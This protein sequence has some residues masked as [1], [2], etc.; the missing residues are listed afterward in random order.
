MLSRIRPCACSSILASNREAVPVRSSKVP[1][2]VMSPRYRFFFLAHGFP[3][4]LALARGRVSHGVIGGKD[5]VIPQHPLGIVVKG[6]DLRGGIVH[7][8]LPRLRQPVLAVASLMVKRPCRLQPFELFR[9][10]ASRPGSG[11]AYRLG[12]SGCLWGAKSS[13]EYNPPPS[14]G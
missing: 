2:L 13:R 6:F 1:P 5:G 7:V 10:A 14:N 3:A 9:N 11:C 4:A 12:R 8:D